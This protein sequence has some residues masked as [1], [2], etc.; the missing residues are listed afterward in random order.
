MKTIEEILEAP[1]IETPFTEPTMTQQPVFENATSF[2]LNPETIQ[3]VARAPE[4][5]GDNQQLI[6]KIQ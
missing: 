2:N 3:F 5:V 6:F 4:I 1:I